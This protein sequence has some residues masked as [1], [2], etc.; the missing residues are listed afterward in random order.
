MNDLPELTARV[1]KLIKALDSD[2]S[3]DEAAGELI[4]LGP[5]IEPV[6]RKHAAVGSP[7]RRAVILARVLKAYE[8]WSADHPDAPAGA[9]EHYIPQSKLSIGAETLVGDIGTKTFT[10]DTP[11]GRHTVGLSAIRRIRAADVLTWS[12]GGIKPEDREVI[13]DMDNQ[14][15]LRGVTTLKTLT[16]QTVHGKFAIPVKR[17]MEIRFSAQAGKSG[18]SV[19]CD[20][21]DEIIGKVA[22]KTMFPLKTP[23][24]AIDIPLDRVA[25]ITISG[26][27]LEAG[28]AYYWSF[29]KKDAVDRIA[30]VK[31]TVTKPVTFAKGII[32][33]APV[34]R[35][36][37]TK[38]VIPSPRLNCNGWRQITFS[39][40]LKFNS[41]STYGNVY[42]RKDGKINCG[43]WL[44][45]G[46][47]YGGKWIG[48]SFGVVL[49]NAK[50]EKVQ[51][52]S[53]KKG[54]KPYPKRGVWRHIV[55]TYD[56][57]YVRVYFNG[58]LDGETKVAIPDLAIFDSPK[59]TTIIGRTSAGYRASWRDTYFP[60]PVDEIKIWRRALNAAEVKLLH[61]QTL[62][63]SKALASA[64]G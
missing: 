19:R 17:I 56:G 37:T 8:S 40:W 38:I 13:V 12:G 33:L 5:S 27:P 22:P 11:Y 28:L 43:P 62:A 15:R 3:R 25:A 1:E 47:T 48:G 24:G 10:I 54:L 52:A 53:L 50:G 7:A 42:G 21:L 46:G 4:A 35:N 34:F 51:P 20:N 60:G 31:G 55:G 9:M 64:G 30:G 45:T 44:A 59:G 61:E 58:K 63:K 2:I 39:A 32:G 29:D 57:R 14:T 6:V 23:H 36:Y 26:G 49:A 18:V 16:V 41:Y